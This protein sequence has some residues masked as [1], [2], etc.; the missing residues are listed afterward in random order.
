MIETAAASLSVAALAAIALPVVLVL[1]LMVCL[2]C[3]KRK[4]A[5][6]FSNFSNSSETN[7]ADSGHVNNSYTVDVEDTNVDDANT[8]SVSIEP[9]PDITAKLKRPQ[10]PLR[11]RI[12]GAEKTPSDTS[13]KLIV[14][15]QPFPRSQLVYLKEL[16]SGWFGKVIESEAEKIAT[17][18]ARS[19]V[20]VKMLKDDASKEE[21]QFFFEEVAP[22]RELEHP[23][24]MRVLGQCTEINPMLMIMEYAAFGTLKQYLRNH[25][26]EQA[27]LIHKNRLIQF[28]MDASKGLACLHEH[29]YLHRDLA[30]RNCLVMGDHTLKIG[31]YGI[32]EDLFKEDYMSSGNDLLP[33]RWM[34]PETLRQENGKWVSADCSKASDIW[35]LG[36]LLWEITS[37]GERPYSMLT[38]E[39]VLQG[40][41]MDKDI[42]LPEPDIGIPNK[43]RLYEVMRFCWMDPS[44]RLEVDK[45]Y[46]LLEQIASKTPENGTAGEDLTF[47]AKWDHLIPNQRHESIDSTADQQESDSSDD[48]NLLD[49]L[50][51]PNSLEDLST[52]L[53]AG[54]APQAPPR[55]SRRKLSVR[56]VTI[57][58]SDDMSEEVPAAD[59]KRG[60]EK[61]PVPKINV[62]DE[63][64]QQTEVVPQPEESE[65]AEKLKEPSSPSTE[66]TKFTSHSTDEEA[67]EETP[68]VS[69]IMVGASSLD[70][71]LPEGG[72]VQ[73]DALSKVKKT[74]EDESLSFST[75]DKPEAQTKTRKTST[76]VVKDASSPSP[77]SSLSGGDSSATFL[78]AAS[79]PSSP[80]N[81]TDAYATASDGTLVIEKTISQ[82]SDF[83]GSG[84]FSGDSGADFGPFDMTAVPSVFQ[85]SSKS[86]EESR[87]AKESDPFSSA[88]SF[89]KTPFTDD[90]GSIAKNDSFGE[91]TNGSVGDKNS[92]I[93]P[94]DST[95]PSASTTMA[96]DEF[97]SFVSESP[98]ASS[99]PLS[100]EA[101]SAPASKPAKQE[102][103]PFVSFGTDFSSL[104]SLNTPKAAESVNQEQVFPSLNSELSSLDSLKTDATL[105]PGADPQSDI[106][107]FGKTVPPQESENK[108]ESATD[109]ESQKT[110]SGQAGFSFDL[111]SSLPAAEGESG[112][113]SAGK[114]S[115]ELTSDLF[116][117][118]SSIPL[119]SS[120][121]GKPLASDSGNTGGNQPPDLFDLGSSGPSTHDNSFEVVQSQEASMSS[122]TFSDFDILSSFTSSGP[123]PTASPSNPF[124]GTGGVPEFAA[125]PPAAGPPAPA[126]KGSQDD[127]LVVSGSTDP[128]KPS[129]SALL[130]FTAFESST[131]DASKPEEENTG[132]TATD[133]NTTSSLIDF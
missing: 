36:V 83:S 115:A 22:F 32:A 41:I 21:Q 23:N 35:S 49:S 110:A 47:E 87:S 122:S 1:A 26:H 34:A 45:V 7:N 93:N 111:I 125:A 128:S 99:K 16:G 19:K 69:Q 65:K 46:K 121:V 114:E 102:A 50:S 81:L 101:T 52:D 86:E 95:A 2:S 132:K 28:A 120:S 25:R 118:F 123:A 109:K 64:G 12:S 4:A 31:D 119:D 84:D 72:D 94:K 42:R 11:P 53:Q 17:G 108:G 30:A 75:P 60:R 62:I 89:N 92:S 106:F 54:A 39:A 104:S 133:A 124:A 116:G 70:K 74:L 96:A 130:D 8:A 79:S 80:G 131:T 78:T 112:K 40:V 57:P 126:E 61:S 38:D 43:D 85:D 18:M 51:D 15:H 24:I 68:N 59:K 20:V 5:G 67:G 58:K 76:P 129:G 3:F 82:F 103:D 127:V 88:S 14:A 56:A 6:G 90:G 48:S 77:S 13:L 9:L 113:S 71:A 107:D 73:P 98:D 10:C 29:D 66:F 117:N 91:F 105:T 55:A 33:I 100:D 37:L 44:E 63:A 97:F 27:T